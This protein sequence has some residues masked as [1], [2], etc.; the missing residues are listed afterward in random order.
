MTAPK[1]VVTHELLLAGFRE[2]GMEPGGL[3]MVHSSLSSFG[4]VEGGAEAVIEALLE[5]IAPGGTLVLPALCQRDKERRE[6][7][8]DIARSP[9]DVGRTTEVFRARHLRAGNV[10]RGAGVPPAHVIRSD[11]FTHSV[12][13]LG[14]LAEEITRGHATAHGRPGPWGERAFG[15]GSPWE[16]LYE[17]NARYCF[18]GVTFRV[19]TLRHFIQSVLLEETLERLPAEASAELRGRAAGW[20]RA[21]IFPWW[22]GEQEEEA[23][24]ARGLITTVPIGGATCRSIPARTDVDTLLQLIRAQPAEWLNP[25]FLPWFLRAAA[26]TPEG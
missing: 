21:G 8:W 19:H 2:L 14:P 10:A 24:A 23:L 13:A 25:E 7:T 15:H 26:T 22:S 9:S 20:N 5:A 17:H 12:A 16:K 1:S 3:V 11:H 18:L 4:Y 6:E